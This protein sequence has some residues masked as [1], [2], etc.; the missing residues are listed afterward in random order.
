[1]EKKNRMLF[2]LL[3]ILAMTGPAVWSQAT[4]KFDD[5]VS[6]D[7][8]AFKSLQTIQKSYKENPGL[9]DT[10]ADMTSWHVELVQDKLIQPM[11]KLFAVIDKGPGHFSGKGEY[12]DA[13][14]KFTDICKESFRKD[15]GFR[16]QAA[17]DNF[18]NW[19]FW[20]AAFS[21]IENAGY[22]KYLQTQK[23]AY[24]I[25]IDVLNV[26]TGALLNLVYLN[27]RDDETIARTFLETTD[28]LVKWVDNIPRELRK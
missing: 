20:A 17:D 9:S 26:Y 19:V 14:S 6:Q 10:V 13:L 12:K 21:E 18:S 16:K 7:P 3:V 24:L 28:D 15:D 22:T 8:Q 23:K 4:L 1:M 2:V 25:G 11:Q 5:Y 27:K